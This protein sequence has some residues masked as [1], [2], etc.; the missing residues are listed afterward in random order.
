VSCDP[1]TVVPPRCRLRRLYTGQV[2]VRGYGIDDLVE[3][4]PTEIFVIG[5]VLDAA[6]QIDGMIGGRQTFGVYWSP[7]NWE[8]HVNNES[9]IAVVDGE[10]LEPGAFETRTLH[11]GSVVEIRHAHTDEAVHRFRVEMG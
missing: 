8:F 9:A 5:R 10:R 6:I 3:V 4:R 2:T 11:H 7:P 1:S